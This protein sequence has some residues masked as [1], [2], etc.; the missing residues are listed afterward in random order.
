MR[1]QHSSTRSWR[2]GVTAL[3]ASALALSLAACGPSD[4]SSKQTKDDPNATVLVWTD[5]TRQPAF[6]AF[7][8]A[9]PG[10][11]IKIEV[12]DPTAILSKIQLANR[13]GR[14]W[15]DVIFDPLPTDVA[16]LASPLF[17]FAQPLDDL[18][19]K[20]VQDGFSTGN[21]GCK[22]DG[23]LYCLQNDIAQDVL[24]YN[25]PKM[26]EFGYSVPT[27]WA[28][29][30]ALGEKV[31]R[32]HPGYIIGAAGGTNIYY[33]YLWSSGCPLQNVKS[34]TQVQI[35]TADPKCTRVAKT[36]DPLLANGSVSRLSPFDPKINKIAKQ[37]KLLMHPAASWFGEFV[38]KA[39]S[40]Y[41][42]KNGQIAAAPMP[43]W[44]GES[45]NYSGAQGGGIYVVSS[46]A[47][48]KAGA[49]AAAQ[50]AA[51]N[52]TYQTT[53][54]TYPAYAPAAE[55]WLAKVKTD[56]FYAE[57]PSA[58]LTAAATKI[59]PAS[60]PTRYPVEGALNS[61]VVAAITAGNTI[62]SALEAL[63]TQLAGLASSSG[64]EV[65]K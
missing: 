32:D 65:I 17:K 40:A 57:D 24:W 12:I 49:V 21:K 37:G 10:V 14:G 5:A 38:F 59:N 56:T 16:A 58:A 43:T 55:K 54:P 64:Y 44:D 61:T 15:P 29:Y 30:K 7:K 18:V 9:N 46:H 22:V 48:N 45:T 2:I 53:A 51:T 41:A 23:K 26:K 20:S 13:V 19:P 28:E 1:P 47:K 6:D 25:K 63:Q 33:D 39:K 36:I 34:S 31:A 4:D 11:K 60:A 35:N 52:E 27:T 50:W 62:A 42:Y 3:T 8:K